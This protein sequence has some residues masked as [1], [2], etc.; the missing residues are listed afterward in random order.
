[1][2]RQPTDR[3]KIFIDDVTD[4]GLVSNIYKQLMKLNIIKINN[5]IKKNGQKT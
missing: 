5:P 4:K 3:R 1:M 2:K